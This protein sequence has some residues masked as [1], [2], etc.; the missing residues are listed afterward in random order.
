MRDLKNSIGVVHLLDPQD[1]VKTDTV[2]KLLDT[3]GFDGAMVA[4][5]IGAITGGGASDYLT[6]VLQECATTEADDFTEVDSGDIVGAFTKIDSS[7]T[8]DSV[9]QVVGYIG[10]KR[11][12][13]VNLDFS[14]GTTSSPITACPVSVV[15]ILGKAGYKP[16]TAPAAV[17]S[18]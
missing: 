17:S 13:R 3:A 2:S 4:V 11:Y 15:G 1:V 12:I 18:T 7:S 14:A 5:S 6:P 8:E 10:G 16:A 9:T